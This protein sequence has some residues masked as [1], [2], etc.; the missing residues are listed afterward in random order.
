MKR[1]VLVA[2]LLVALAHP[3]CASY[4]EARESSG[5]FALAWLALL[6][7][8]DREGAWAE[9]ARLTR[10]RARKEDSLKAWFGTRDPFGE[11]LSRKLQTNWERD[12][13]DSAPDGI[14]R[15]IIFW[16]D[17]EHSDFV[18]ERLMLTRE[19][20]EWKLLNYSLK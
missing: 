7:A 9:T 3:S 16:S 6:D 4:R 12:W 8:G 1:G 10:L 18:E 20:G 2:C 15:E 19:D 5:E 17:F 14:Y 11:V 13:L